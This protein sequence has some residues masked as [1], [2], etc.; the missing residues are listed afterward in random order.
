MKVI[1]DRW[2]RN[3]IVFHNQREALAAVVREL[4]V[5]PAKSSRTSCKTG[6]TCTPEQYMSKKVINTSF[7][8]E[9]HQASQIR[10]NVCRSLAI[11]KAA[12]AAVSINIKGTCIHLYADNVALAEA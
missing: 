5:P 8:F 10:C 4:K 1:I 3:Q 6:F 2:N 9:P 7:P 12:P 11:I